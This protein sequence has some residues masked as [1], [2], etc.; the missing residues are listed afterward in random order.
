MRGSGGKELSSRWATLPGAL[1]AIV[2]IAGLTAIAYAAAPSGAQKGNAERAPGSARHW[3]PIISQHPDKIVVSTSARFDFNAGRRGRGFRC[4]LD[5][6]NWG[7]CH[8]PIV[9][10][11]LTPGKHSF[12]V[13]ALDRKGQ[14][15]GTTRFR[16]RIL[17][18]KDF[19]IVPRLS[20]IGA[21]YPGAPAVALP[22]TIDNPNSVPILVTGLQVAATADPPG[23]SRAENLLFV[24]AGLSRKAPLRIPAGGSATL[25]A[26]GVSP[27]GI[28]LRDLP[29]NQDACQNAQFPLA[30][31]GKAHG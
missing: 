14:R 28:Q 11:R 17:E 23:C 13:R 22:V 16:W 15:S 21:L 6:H 31:S 1:L 19:T 10:A 25:P 30:F 2:A 18:P 9:L 4:R 29:V 24:P 20:G 7:A 3:R 26:A 5:D 8:P 27:P 12:A